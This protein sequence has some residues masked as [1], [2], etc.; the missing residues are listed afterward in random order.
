MSS[1]AKTKLLA[2]AELPKGFLVDGFPRD[3]EQASAFED[4]VGKCSVII[5]YGKR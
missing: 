1:K 2:T 4:H 5:Y 3:V